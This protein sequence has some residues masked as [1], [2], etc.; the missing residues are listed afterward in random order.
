MRLL[1]S[2]RETIDTV[3]TSVWKLDFLD[4]TMISALKGAD[5]WEKTSPSIKED[6]DTHR[7]MLKVML[8]SLDSSIN[9]LAFKRDKIRQALEEYEGE[10]TITNSNLLQERDEGS[11]QSDDPSS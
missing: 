6:N 3:K 7:A 4:R 8:A 5:E 10:R 2:L 1:T 11:S 9:T